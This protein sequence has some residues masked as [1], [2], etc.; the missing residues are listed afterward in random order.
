M[1]SFKFIPASIRGVTVMA[2][3]QIGSFG[4]PAT[5]SCQS[6]EPKSL[7]NSNYLNQNQSR[8]IT[9]GCLL[10]LAASRTSVKTNKVNTAIM[11]ADIDLP[12]KPRKPITPWLAFVREKKDDI[13]KLKE[14]MAAS[15]LATILAKEWKNTDKTKYEREYDE[16]YQEYLRQV[17]NYQN[18]LTDQHRNYLNL[19]KDAKRESKALRQLRK[20]KIPVWPRNSANLFCKERCKQADIKEQM[21]HRKPHDVFRDLFKEYRALTDAEKKKY[22]DMQEEDKSRFQNEFLA[23]Y[24]G[25]QSNDELNRSALEQAN[26]MRDRLKALNYI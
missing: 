17:Q 19:K 7:I 6:I 1:L 15:E 16:K 21:K 26:K 25:V 22:I 18:S 20:T 11:G 10:N 3:N 23:W 2:S 9:T 24:E 8:M 5:I 4:S 12:T 14:K 13:L